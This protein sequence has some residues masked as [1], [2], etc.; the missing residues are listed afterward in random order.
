M[1]ITF[2]V[3]PIIG[4]SIYAGG[5]QW[6]WDGSTWNAVLGG[7]DT[8][9]WTKTATAGQTSA[10]GADDTGLSLAYNVGSEQV[11]LNGSLLSRGVDYTGTNGESISFTTALSAD[12]V[13]D[14]VSFSSF[15]MT[16]SVKKT[17]IL[18]KGDLIVGTGYKDTDILPVGGT[19]NVLIADPSQVTG[20]RW[21]ENDITPIDTLRYQFDGIESRFR[22]TYQG[23][24]I[25]IS[26]P[27][28]ILLSVNGIIQTVSFPEYV[29]QS[30]L[31]R[32]GFMVDDDGY[33]A[34]SEVPPAGSTFDARIM[35][36]PVTNTKTTNYP[37]LAT[38]ILLGA[39]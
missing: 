39:Y 18:A 14:I 17:E 34:F 33:L 7:A 38:D 27:L 21:V 23:S 30:D 8:I 5:R 3:S 32:D 15:Q 36:G 16:D 10:T 24:P 11:Y 22:P 12:D 31:G 1:A 26:N 2:P 25:T 35:A 20:V 19:N 29:W 9:R 6:T 28:R 37:F 13:I 4:A